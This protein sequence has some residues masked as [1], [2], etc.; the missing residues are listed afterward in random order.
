MAHVFISYKRSDYDF[1]LTLIGELGEAGF[2]AWI[3]DHIKTGDDWRE[4]IDQAIRD[5]FAVIAVMTPEAKASE[6]VT[7]EWAFALGIGVKVIPIMYKTTQ[8]HPRLEALQ[9]LDFTSRQNRPWDRLIEHLKQLEENYD[10]NQVRLPQNFPP[11]I[12]QALRDLESE[13]ST[14]YGDAL[15]TLTIANHPSTI[16][17]LAVAA[18][19]PNRAMR[20]RAAFA[21]AE[22]TLYEDKRAIPGLQDAL[23]VDDMEIRK[24][25]LRCL[26]AMA[27][28]STVPSLIKAMENR[29]TRQEAGNALVQ[30]GR[31][32]LYGLQKVIRNSHDKNLA[33]VALD[34]ANQIGEASIPLLVQ[35]VNTSKDEELTQMAVRLL[36]EQGDPSTSDIVVRFLK[37]PAYWLRREAARSLGKIKSSETVPALIQALEDQDVGVSSAAREALEMIGTPEAVSAVKEWELKIFKDAEDPQE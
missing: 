19:H 35:I 13:D 4:A 28:P 29:E 10:P 1:V 12:S 21:L 23:S 27:D 37:H 6:Y 16:E 5:A 30:I 15:H 25:A 24:S 14:I 22:T 2:S 36:G 20:I 9:Y 17:A 33:Y 31:D 34:F 18:Q 26:G 3:D 32:A 11:F 7:Y 8:L